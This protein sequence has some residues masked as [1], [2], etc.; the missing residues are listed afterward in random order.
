[1][2]LFD[3]HWRGIREAVLVSVVHTCLC[4]VHIVL[5]IGLDKGEQEVV[6]LG[7]ECL[8]AGHGRDLIDRYVLSGV[9]IRSRLLVL[10]LTALKLGM[11]ESLP[12]SV[13][14]GRLCS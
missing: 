7:F 10:E 11:H 3:S 5:T 4:W 14:A 13:R 12:C 6:C 8:M 9:R 1:M 2:L